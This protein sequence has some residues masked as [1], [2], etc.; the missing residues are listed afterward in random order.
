MNVKTL[1]HSQQQ[2]QPQGPKT[3]K[4]KSTIRLTCRTVIYILQKVP[5]FG[6]WSCLKSSARHTVSNKTQLKKLPET[7]NL[8]ENYA[9]H[10]FQAPCCCFESGLAM[11]LL[12]FETI[13]VSVD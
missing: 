3:H 12:L 9:K 5:S 11:D 10:T 8:T 2:Q 6:S 13:N 1:T 7:V 4:M